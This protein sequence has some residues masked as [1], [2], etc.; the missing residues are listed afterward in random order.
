MRRRGV[1][2]RLATSSSGPNS[3]YSV[4]ILLHMDQATV[5]K[6]RATVGAVASTNLCCLALSLPLRGRG[7]GVLPLSDS[8]EIP[9]PSFTESHALSKEFFSTIGAGLSS[10]SREVGAE[11]GSLLSIGIGVSVFAVLFLDRAGFV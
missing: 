7:A 1:T 6:P 3:L 2:M 4:P 11:V 9:S 5:I 8:V 10:K